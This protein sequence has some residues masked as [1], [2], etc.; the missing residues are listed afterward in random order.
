MAPPPLAPLPPPPPPE[1]PPPP[2]SRLRPWA[3]QLRAAARPREGSQSEVRAVPKTSPQMP[4]IRLDRNFVTADRRLALPTA[5]D[6]KAAEPLRGA[7]IALCVADAEDQLS[8]PESVGSAESI[9]GEIVRSW[10]PAT[11][12]ERWHYS[13]DRAVPF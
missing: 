6:R 7:D 12:D 5:L 13:R 10:D 9:S 4:P 2:I 1:P 8:E 11:R 3:P